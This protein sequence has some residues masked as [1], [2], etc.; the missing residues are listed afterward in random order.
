[1]R[2]KKGGGGEQTERE[3]EQTEQTA[4]ERKGARSDRDIYDQSR[5]IKLV[6]LDSK[7]HILCNTTSF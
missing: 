1:M 3:C 5:P 4:G 6:Y 2:E 7:H